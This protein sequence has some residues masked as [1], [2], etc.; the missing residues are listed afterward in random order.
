MRCLF[1]KAKVLSMMRLRQVG[2]AVRVVCVATAV[3]MLRSAPATATVLTFDDLTVR[4]SFS[5]QGIANTY[6]GFEW[7]YG[8]SLGVF[9]PTN[10]ATG[11]ASATVSVPA[12]NNGPAPVSG[13]SYAWTYNG[14]QSL[15]VDFGAAYD[16]AGAYFATLSSSFGSNA[17][18]VRL[19]GYDAANSLVAST[20]ALALTNSFQFLSAG[21][22]GVNRLEIRADA[23]NRWF[24]ID[25]LDVSRTVTA[26]A[27]P[28][29]ATM[30][31]LGSGMVGAIA[32]RR[33]A[34]ASSRPQ[35]GA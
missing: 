23:D 5:N 22:V 4:D 18:S 3:L 35:P 10:T 14:P 20:G 21:F 6:H 13:S 34:R 1:P 17:S 32:R 27:T 9:V 11:W 2:V 8:N 19:F 16:V 30:V 31:L 7:G 12:I 33:R 15:F 24:T 28:E 26:A 25:D 29:P